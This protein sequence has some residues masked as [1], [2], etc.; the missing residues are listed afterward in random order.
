[1]YLLLHASVVVVEANKQPACKSPVNRISNPPANPQFMYLLLHASVI[2]ENGFEA[3][4][5][6]DNSACVESSEGVGN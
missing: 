4:D 6:E 2:E 3:Q 1:M 5:G